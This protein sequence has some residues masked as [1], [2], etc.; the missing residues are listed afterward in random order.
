V[1]LVRRAGLPDWLGVIVKWSFGF[2][3]VNVLCLQ[4]EFVLDKRNT[5]IKKFSALAGAIFTEMLNISNA[6]PYN[7][8]PIQ[9][10]SIFAGGNQREETF[11][12]SVL[13][14]AQAISERSGNDFNVTY[15]FDVNGKMYLLGNWYERRGAI[16]NEDL[17]AGYN[18]ELTDNILEVDA[19]ELGNWVEGRGDAN[20]D[21]TRPIS[22]AY[23]E[24][25]IRKY[26]L[27][28]ISLVF[29]GNREPGTVEENTL[30]K[31]KATLDPAQSYDI[32]VL[33]VGDIFNSL[34]IGNV[35]N[36]NLPR[37]GFDDSGNVGTRTQVET[38][39]MAVESLE[40]TV[41]LIV[42]K[43]IPSEA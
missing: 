4:I 42:E 22:I 10:G 23:N 36:L 21:G 43:Y 28:Q 33:D 12:G 37:D 27:N 15:A 13:S 6:N 29:D 3:S 31:L 16:T 35:H 40:G 17:R 19:R 8:K 38:L 14:H 2:G 20:T 26:G 18:I 11:G 9:P 25:S 24:D 34:D 1:V 32:T 5:P 39:G 7:E 30:N 41:R